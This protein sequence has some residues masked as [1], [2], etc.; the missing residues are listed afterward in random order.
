MGNEITLAE[1][2]VDMIPLITGYYEEDDIKLPANG[3]SISLKTQKVNIRSLEGSTETHTLMSTAVNI[4]INDIRLSEQ[5]YITGTFRDDDSYMIFKDAADKY[6]EKM[7][8]Y[9]EQFSLGTNELL[10]AP[11]F[12][13][14]LMPLEFMGKVMIEMTI[15]DYIY[16]NPIS[17]DFLMSFNPESISI[18]TFDEELDIP[19]LI[20]EVKRKQKEDLIL[21]KMI[22]EEVTEEYTNDYSNADIDNPLFGKTRESSNLFRRSKMEDKDNE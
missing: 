10:E 6:N 16:Y 5:C 13:L 14:N 7:K 9:E 20:S 12:T 3:S 18:T 19:G 21:S 11:I 22:E 15:P 17:L 4:I 8:V 1:V 2:F